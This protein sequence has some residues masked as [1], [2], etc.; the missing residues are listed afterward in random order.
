MFSARLAKAHRHLISSKN[1]L[2]FHIVLFWNDVND[3]DRRGRV[4]INAQDSGLRRDESWVK[5][6]DKF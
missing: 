3:F 5:I 4:D 1:G 2:L 6:D